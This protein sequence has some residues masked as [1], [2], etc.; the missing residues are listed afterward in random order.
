MAQAPRVSD[1]VRV[2]TS[3]HG[4]RVET[5]DSIFGPRGD[6]KFRYLVKDV[7]GKSPLVTQPLPEDDDERLTPDV[8]RGLCRQVGIPVEEFGLTLG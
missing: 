7:E 4:C 8:L 2:A 3:K 1:F 5:D 6:V